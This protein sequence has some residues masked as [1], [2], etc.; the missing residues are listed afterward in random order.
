MSEKPHSLVGKRLPDAK[1]GEMVDGEIRPCVAS[2]LFAVGRAVIVGMPGAFTPIC[3][4]RHLP[5][6]VANAERL[7][8]GGVKHLACIVTSDPFAIDPWRKEIDP[9]GK[10]RF[11]SDGNLSLARTLGLMSHEPTLFLGERSARYVI[12]TDDG[13]VST[14]RVENSILEVG[15]TAIDTLDLG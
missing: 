13:V 7:R 1:L 14:V 12:L 11:L 3:S 9:S 10:I 4:G 8:H 2:E 6:L 5:N 15:C